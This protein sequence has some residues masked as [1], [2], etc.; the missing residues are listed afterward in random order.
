VIYD[1]QKRFS[2]AIEQYE[3]AIALSPQ[4]GILHNNLVVCYYLQDRYEEAIRSFRKA[5]EVDPVNC[6]VYNNLELRLGMSGQDSEA[7]AAFKRGGGLAQ[8]YN[9]LGC[10]YLQ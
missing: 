4:E 2:E 8:A 1:Y 3:A 9:N 7:L 6:R 10:V 5:L